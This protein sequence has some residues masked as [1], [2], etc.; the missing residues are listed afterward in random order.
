MI[1][2]LIDG[3]KKKAAEMNIDYE[4]IQY[5]FRVEAAF[6]IDIIIALITC[7][8]IHKTLQACVFILCFSYLRTY[9]GGYH[10]K[11]YITCG[12]AYVTM[13]FVCSLLEP[14]ITIHQAPVIII[15]PLIYLF[16]ISP[17]QNENNILNK[18]EIAI[19]R[20]K[21]R[22]RLIAMSIAYLLFF[23]LSKYMVL[24][25]M[26][27]SVSCL[28]FLCILQQYKEKQNG[29]TVSNHC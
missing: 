18:R 12:L 24:T 13:I 1:Q 28:S 19:Y 14:F 25:M 16:M 29:Q 8:I 20:K 2:W 9:C 3:T 10:C 6:I 26:F 21:A 5:G 11:T 23:L 22:F 27:F 15:V 17:V 4:I 7:T